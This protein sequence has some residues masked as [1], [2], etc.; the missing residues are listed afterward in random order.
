MFAEEFLVGLGRGERPDVL[1]L[2]AAVGGAHG[3]VV[4]DVF[5][6]PVLGG[7]EEGLGGVGEVAAGEV[8]RRVGFLPRDLVEQLHAKLLHGVAD[9]EDDMMRAA[10]PEG[11]VGFEEGLAAAE[12]LGVEVV[13]L[14]GAAGFVPGA[15]V[16]LHHPA[17]VAGDAA[18]GE[19]VGR[20]GED[21]VE[22]ALRVAFEQVVHDLEAVAVVEPEA[23]GVV[24]VSELARLQ[25][26]GT[27]ADDAVL[28]AP[29]VVV[30]RIVRQRGLLRSAGSLNRV[31]V[32]AGHLGGACSLG[33]PRHALIGSIRGGKGS[34]HFSGD[35]GRK[36]KDEGQHRKAGP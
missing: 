16:H 10:D 24:A 36:T 29:D 31:G 21:E 23:A 17:G 3:V 15:L 12:P 7:P 6:L 14:G 30:R 20:V 22:D 1:H 8:G 26:V 32:N 33:F 4:E 18:V 2:L 9:G 28:G 11:A 5:A 27:L 35:E 25:D 34:R 13:V 19:E